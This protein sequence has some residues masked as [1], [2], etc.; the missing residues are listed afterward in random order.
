[1]RNES[2]YDEYD[3]KNNEQM[4]QRHSAD[5]L[6]ESDDQNTM[7]FCTQ[8][9]R[10]DQLQAY[11][12]SHNVSRKAQ[13]SMF[14]LE[15]QKLLYCHITKVAGTS[16]KTLMLQAAGSDLR[17]VTIRVHQ[18][19]FMK[20]HGVRRLVSY[21]RV[22]QN[23]M[24]ENYYKVI[25]VKHPFSRLVSMWNDKFVPRQSAYRRKLG[26]VILDYVRGRNRTLDGNYWSDRPHFHEVIQYMAATRHQDNHWKPYEPFCH[27]CSVHWDAILRTE[28][29]L[30]ESHLLLDKLNLTRDINQSI[31][32][33]HSH[34]KHT[35]D[36]YKISSHLPV[37]K[38]VTDDDMRHVLATYGPDLERFGYTWDHSR[39]VAKCDIRTQNG[40]CC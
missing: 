15:R 28:T 31:P 8:Q 40:N 17:N 7:R 9:E 33:I 29:L 16:L 22:E 24:L 10:H 37:F 14:V 38:D 32:L 13:L 27:P 36:L 3:V 26:R 34:T 19:K 11:C 6:S 39:S 4:N 1:M 5:E 30:R 23:Y 12:S 25:V 2:V 18:P 35:Q 21:T 20:N